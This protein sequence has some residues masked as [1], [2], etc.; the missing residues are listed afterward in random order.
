MY[1]VLCIM[2]NDNNNDNDNDNKINNIT[3]NKN[4]YDTFIF[5]V[6]ETV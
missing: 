4:D 1:N 5:S 3:D 2:Y 6:V